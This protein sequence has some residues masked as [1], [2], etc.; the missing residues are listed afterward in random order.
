MEHFISNILSVGASSLLFEFSSTQSTM[1]CLHTPSKECPVKMRFYSFVWPLYTYTCY[2][3]QISWK[4]GIFTKC[5]LFQIWSF[6]CNFELKRT[7]I[8]YFLKNCWEWR[9]WE[10][11]CFFWLIILSLSNKEIYANSII[12]L[13][14][15][16]FISN[17]KNNFINM[18]LM[19]D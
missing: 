13:P 15:L 7:G 2:R 16:W 6:S 18:R 19:L 4:Y 14:Y 5:F 11:F 3:S 1:R 17:L 10:E 9:F 12:Y 8:K